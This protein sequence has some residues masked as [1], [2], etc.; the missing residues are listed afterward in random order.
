MPASCNECGRALHDPESKAIG[1]GPECRG[2]VARGE[3]TLRGHL[4]AASQAGDGVALYWRQRL[5]QGKRLSDMNR[6]LLEARFSRVRECGKCHVRAQ[7]GQYV[8]PSCGQAAFLT[9]VPV[10]VSSPKVVHASEAT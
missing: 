6:R 1:I 8:C 2:K 9:I 7:P 10:L 3:R 5:A 4:A